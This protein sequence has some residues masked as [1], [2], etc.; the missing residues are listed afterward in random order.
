M[1]VG[2]NLLTVSRS[3]GTKLAGIW[4]AGVEVMKSPGRVSGVPNRSSA[5]EYMRSLLG[6]VLMPSNTQRKASNQ[7]GPVSYAQ[8]ANFKCLWNRSTKLFAYRWYAAVQCSLMSRSFVVID[9]NFVVN[10][11]PLSEVKA[12]GMSKQAIQWKTNSLA[13]VLVS[14]SSRVIASG[15]LVN[16]AT[17]VRRWV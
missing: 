12:N 6:A 10:W 13:H 8:R 16:W 4:V 9:H 15:H 11:K 17:M 7:F 5:E 14:V 3:C 2:E 1:G